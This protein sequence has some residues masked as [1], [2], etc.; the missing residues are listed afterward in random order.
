MPHI[1]VLHWECNEGKTCSSEA[2]RGACGFY[3]KRSLSSVIILPFD[4]A[5]FLFSPPLMV[6]GELF[7]SLHPQGILT[8]GKR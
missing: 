8:L 3:W 4:F 2:R 7:M 5:C 6:A 1:V